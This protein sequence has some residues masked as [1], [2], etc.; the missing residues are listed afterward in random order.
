VINNGD[1]TSGDP[2]VTVTGSTAFEFTTNACTVPLPGGASCDVG[3]TYTGTGSAE[4]TGVLAASATPG[5]TVTAELTGSPVALT[6]APISTGPGSG[7]L[8][9][10]TQG[11]LARVEV[12][13][14]GLTA[15]PPR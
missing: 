1:A 10:F 7:F 14:E 12:S 13:G 9:Y 3:L 2:T 8:D 11:A 4:Q 5:G 6:V 15:Q